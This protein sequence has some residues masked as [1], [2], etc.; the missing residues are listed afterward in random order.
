MKYKF[1]VTNYKFGD[2]K[3]VAIQAKTFEMA[4]A[5][6]IAKYPNTTITL[7]ANKLP[8]SQKEQEFCKSVNPIL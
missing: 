4:K 6:I 7:M 5:K 3:K 1:L 8:C 2:A